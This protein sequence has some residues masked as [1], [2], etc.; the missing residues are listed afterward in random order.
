MD[1]DSGAENLD[2]MVELMEEHGELQSD[3]VGLC[4][5]FVEDVGENKTPDVQNLTGLKKF[6]SVYQETLEPIERTSSATPK[7]SSLLHILLQ[8]QKISGS[9]KMHV[10]PTAISRGRQGITKGSSTS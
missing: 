7:L 9:R 3:I 1:C 5:S 6:F 4:N 2:L 8:I 10:Q